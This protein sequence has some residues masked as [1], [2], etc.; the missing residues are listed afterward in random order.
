MRITYCNFSLL[1]CVLLVAGC[2]DSSTEHDED[3]AGSNE[4]TACRA[5][6]GITPI[7][8][9]KN[10]E[11]LVQLPG[12]QQLLVSEMGA[13]MTDAPGK[14]LIYD[15]AAAQQLDLPIEWS[16]GEEVWGDSACTAPE[17]DLFSPHGIDLSLKGNRL[18]LLVVNHGGR[19]AVEF[20]EVIAA[21]EDWTLQ[22]MGCALP[23]GD[24]FINDVVA[25]SDGGFLVTHMW[26]KSIAFEEVG[27]RLLA[28]EK[29]GWV[30]EWQ[31][32][33]GFSFVANSQ[34][35]MPNG[36]AVSKDNKKIFINVYM[37]NKI[38]KLDRGSGMVEG[39]FEIRQPDNVTLDADGMLWIASHQQDPLN[40]TCTVEEG[41]CLLPFQVARVDSQTMLG[42]TV[43]EHEG[44]PMG[45]VTVALKVDN[46]I[47][48]GSAHGD[49]IARVSLP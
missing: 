25:L 40:D 37:G 48:M 23:P 33:T 8:G 39:T 16:A 28:G 46:E 36:I 29:M 17:P 4:I 5:V 34:E 42:E 35:V 2:Q 47:Y 27:R 38:I 44:A 31:A 45:Y 7:C 14:L 32:E 15:I 26:N 21:D 12:T 19:E 6:D 20:F 41:P 1:F 22:W 49:R 13:F 30:W 9:F 11:D 24:P 18:Q 3:Q 10:P 43:L